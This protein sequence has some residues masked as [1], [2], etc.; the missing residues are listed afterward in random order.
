MDCRIPAAIQVISIKI[1]EIPIKIKLQW[2]GHFPVTGCKSNKEE[3]FP[4][5]LSHLEVGRTGSHSHGIQQSPLSPGNENAGKQIPAVWRGWMGRSRGTRELS[6][7]AA[8]HSA[9]N[10]VLNC[11][12]GA[13]PCAD[14]AHRG[15]PVPLQLDTGEQPWEEQVTCP[16]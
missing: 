13:A 8:L 1:Q 3:V 16:K 6:A 9:W 14:G 5:E 7:Q 4:E 11:S 12:A 10:S 15:V 2:K